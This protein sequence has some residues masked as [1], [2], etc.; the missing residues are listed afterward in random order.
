MPKP[1]ILPKTLYV[2]GDESGS[3][4]DI[5]GKVIIIALVTTLNPSELRFIVKKVHKQSLD[6]K[7]KR[8]KTR[9]HKEFKYHTAFKPDREKV[10]QLLRSKEIE[11]FLL[12]IKKGG[13]KIVDSPLNYGI[14]LLEILEPLLRHYH[15]QNCNVELIL[16]KHFTK[17]EDIA[18]LNKLIVQITNNQLKP[19][20]VDSQ[21]NPFVALADFVAGAMREEFEQNNKSLSL[22]IADNIIF[23]EKILWRDLKRKWID[24]IKK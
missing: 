21:N 9:R 3:L 19:V 11:I 13:K 6:R 12:C 7:S 18:K 23:K 10:L 16:D 20:H 15:D 1:K 17:T 14:A 24:K 8:Y 2:Y 22:I 4:A 5:A